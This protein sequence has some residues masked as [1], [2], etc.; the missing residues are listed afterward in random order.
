MFGKNKAGKKE[1]KNALQEAKNWYADRYQFVVVQR[2]ILIL[3]TLLALA[4]LGATTFAVARLTESKTFEPYVIEVEQKTGL[5]TLVDRYSKNKYTADEAVIRYFVNKYIHMRESY[6]VRQYKYNYSKVIRY[7]SS[8]EVYSAFRKYISVENPRSPLNL[9][10]RFKR[11]VFVKSISFL[12]KKKVQ[13][14]VETRDSTYR[15]KEEGKGHVV[16]TLD[17]DFLELEL[18]PEGRY[19]NPLGFQVLSYSNDEDVS[20]EK[21]K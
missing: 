19:I 21:D 10:N 5:T 14:R 8:P 12:D 11:E 4:G 3:I 1:N 18:S 17:F 7:L 2:N 13:A 6:D 9:G 16:I 20:W 15:G